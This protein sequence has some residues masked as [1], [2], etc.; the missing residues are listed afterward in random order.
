M[1]TLETTMFM[2]EFLT[3]LFNPVSEKDF[4][5]SIDKS[6]KQA[7]VGNYQEADEAIDQISDELKI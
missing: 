2:P 7:D 4:M 1:K 6:I 5:E 3:G